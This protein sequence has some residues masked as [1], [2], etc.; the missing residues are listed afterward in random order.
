MGVTRIVWLALPLCLMACGG[1]EPGTSGEAAGGV[2]ANAAASGELVAR[3]GSGGV[4]TD[5][6]VQRAIRT[7]QAAAGTLTEDDRKDLL[8]KLVVDEAL[9]Q[10]SLAEGLHRDPKVRK[11]LINLLLREKV[12][13]D[14]AAGEFS[15]E[16]L[17]AYFDSHPEEF[18][19]PE[20]RQVKRLFLSVKPD[21]TMEQ[22]RAEATDLR[23]RIVAAPETFSDLANEHSDGVY[24]HRG[25]DV[26]YV[27]AT[28]KPGIDPVVV[29]EA[30]KLEIGQVSEP[31]ETE[32]GVNIVMVANKR[33]AVERGFSHMKA[34]VL[35]KLKNE[36]Y[37]TLTESFI[38]EVR[39]RYTVDVDEAALNA[40]DLQ[41]ARQAAMEAG[42]EGDPMMPQLERP[43]M[44]GTPEGQQRPTGARPRAPMPGL[45][46]QKPAEAGQ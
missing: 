32:G 7:P 13:G 31:F 39:Q 22:A 16:E 46:V 43:L 24:R 33:E 25:G 38:E 4:T 9:W 23:A 18:T 11:I 1:N 3:V 29:E 35:R 19:M 30:F 12:Y 10:E 17:K 14:P 8:D 27:A 2:A 45:N 36:R 26:G 21:R 44:P 40:V 5:D 37:K 41:Q 6:F 15:D 42:P 20:R 28:G 34:S